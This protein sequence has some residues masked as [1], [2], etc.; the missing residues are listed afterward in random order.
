MEFHYTSG[1]DLPS[2]RSFK[3]ALLIIAAAALITT[4]LGA[5]VYVGFHWQ[6]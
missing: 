2:A 3:T 6:L 5:A 4:L 1:L